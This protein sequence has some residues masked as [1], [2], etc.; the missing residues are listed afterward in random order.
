MTWPCKGEE[1]LTAEERICL[2]DIPPT[3][4]DK[5]R[6]RDARRLAKGKLPMCYRFRRKHA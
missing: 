4:S 1:K 6:R 5:N 2:E 3:L